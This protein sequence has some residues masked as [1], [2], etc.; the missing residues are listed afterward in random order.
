M[1]QL[2]AVFAARPHPTTGVASRVRQV[3]PDLEHKRVAVAIWFRHG[4]L[5]KC[6][7]VTNI[8]P[9]QQVL[10]VVNHGMR[11]G[12]GGER[13]GEMM[14][15][16]LVTSWAKDIK[17]GNRMI[18]AVSET[19]ATKPA[20]RSAFRRRRCLVL[21]DGFF[22]WRKEGKQRVPL[23]FSQKSG[24]PMAFA[25]LW[26]NWQSPEGE[27]IRSCT[28]LTTAANSFIEPVHNRMPVILS[29]ETEPLWLDP[30]TET[31]AILEP[32]LI[33]APSDLLDVREVS[34]VVNNVRNQGPDC[35][36]PLTP[37]E[38]VAAVQ[39]AAEASP[40]VTNRARL[41]MASMTLAA[42]LAAGLNLFALSPLLPLTIEEYEI[43]HWAAG[44]LVTLPMLVGAAIGI[45]G[46]I[47]IARVGVKR[48]YMWAWIAMALLALA[49]VVPNFYV[50]LF[51]RLAYGVGLAFMVVA[52]GPLVMQW[53]KPREML[54][55]NSLNTAILSGG[56]A[57]S[58][59]GAVPL[60]D[61]LGWK[62]TLTVFSSVGFIGTFLWPM[63][64]KDRD[65]GGRTA[66][67][68]F[69]ERS[70][71]RLARAGGGFARSRRRRN[72]HSVHSADHVAADLLW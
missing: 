1:G 63:V 12:D 47:L 19:S 56:V 20:F 27:W 26:E 51:L 45:P 55:V 46:G 68:H 36:A 9:T 58:L 37:S 50:L 32:L 59:A 48:A 30:L 61:L 64:P 15:W 33:S 39:L 6:N 25:G 40:A 41:F 4:N 21:A 17:I 62:L 53:F 13:R 2:S 24:E 35:V 69:G 16:G 5:R 34:P 54:V 42:H 72:I 7:R 23:Y 43:S 29:S 18:N 49:P 57:A 44:L 8:A 11:Q 67:R 66:H 65:T 70:F 60:A 10:A 52:T 14:R 28:I 22:E 38:E 3:H 71:F 31:P